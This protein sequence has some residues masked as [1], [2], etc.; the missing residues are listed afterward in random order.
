MARPDH[1]P[2]KATRDTVSLHVLAGTRQDVIADVLGIDP[3][4]LRKHYRKELDQAM[5]K[6]NAKIGGALYNKALGGDTSAL[7]FWAKTRMGFRETQ[8]IDHTTAG[9]PLAPTRIELVAPTAPDENG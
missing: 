3:K 8:H 5:A 9:K 2:T 4:T 1:Q 7:I 6:A